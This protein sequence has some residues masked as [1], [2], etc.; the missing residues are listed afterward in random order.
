MKLCGAW[1]VAALALA[2]T[3]AS[4]LAGEIHK[5]SGA[6]RRQHSV[7]QPY[8]SKLLLCSAAGANAGA[9]SGRGER[10]HHGLVAHAPDLPGC[11]LWRLPLRVCVGVQWV[12]AW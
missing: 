6:V 9:G 10:G 4:A 5:P 8:M 12:A 11:V 3:A 1:V 7:T 2:L